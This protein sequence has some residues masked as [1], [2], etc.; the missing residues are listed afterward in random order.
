MRANSIFSFEDG[1]STRECFAV[2]AFLIRVKKSAIGSVVILP[3]LPTCLHHAGNFS[4][5]R[6][7]AETDAAQFKSAQKTPG[8]SAYAATVPL[9]DLELQLPLHFREL[10]GTRHASLVS[11]SPK[12][13]AE[14][15]QQLAPFFVTSCCGRYGNVHAFDFVHPGVIDLGENQLVFDSDGVVASAIKRIRRQAFKVTNARQNNG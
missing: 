6:V 11:L 13:N 14:Q 9:A 4:L 10:T 15:L 5:E 12:R 3:S 8:A 7:A 1:I 2:E